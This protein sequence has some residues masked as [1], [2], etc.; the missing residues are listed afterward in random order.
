MDPPVGWLEGEG[1][2]KKH[3][4]RRDGVVSCPVID[5]E[6]R[7][8]EFSPGRY[9]TGSSELVQSAPSFDADRV[10]G[11]HTKETEDDVVEGSAKNG[12]VSFYMTRESS[13]QKEG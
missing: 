10:V 9:G 8:P 13:Y 5:V 7:Q 1:F 2:G 3:E 4:F 6:E 12:G 11:R